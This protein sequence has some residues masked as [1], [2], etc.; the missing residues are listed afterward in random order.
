MYLLEELQSSL[1]I[2]KIIIALID[3]YIQAKYKIVKMIINK[4]LCEAQI[5][6]LLAGIKEE[7]PEKLY[8]VYVH[9]LV[10]VKDSAIWLTKGNMK[11]RDE[12]A[13]CL[14]QDRNIFFGERV[15]CR[16]ANKTVDHL[17]TKSDRMLGHNYTRRH[18]E[19]LMLF[20]YHYAINIFSRN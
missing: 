10:N 4:N 12:G 19:V 5:K 7:Y 8:R 20:T 16:A 17:V 18:N 2:R 3:S 11:L 9:E 1:Q 14:L 6:S 15:H 13:Y